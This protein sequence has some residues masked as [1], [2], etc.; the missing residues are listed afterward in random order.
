M[1]MRSFNRN[2]ISRSI[3]SICGLNKDGTKGEARVEQD[4]QIT[5]EKG[6]GKLIQTAIPIKDVA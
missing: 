5:E 2:K 6:V 4:P 3:S 1:M